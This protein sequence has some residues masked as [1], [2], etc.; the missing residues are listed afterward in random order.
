MPI[1]VGLWKMGEMPQRV[2]FSAMETE[3]RLED[4]LAKDLSILDP[5]L[6]LIGRQVPTAYG[7][8]I[9]LLA[10]DREGNLNVIELKRNK[11]PREVVAQVL[12]YGS[13]VRNL[14]DDDI[15]AIFDTYK[16]KYHPEDGTT[17]LDEA[18]CKYFGVEEMPEAI[19]ES[20]E[21]IVVAAELDHSTERIINYL[22]EF[23]VAINAVFFRF[24]KDGESEYLSRAWLIEPDRVEENVIGRREKRPWNGEFYVSFGS[25]PIRNWE[26]ARKY[27]FISAG[28]GSW[29]TKT[30]GTLEQGARIWVNIPRE[31][32]VGVGRVVDKV[33]PVEEFLV[34]DGTGNRVPIVDLPLDIAK[35]TKAKDDADNA[36]HLVRVEWIKTV[37]VSEAI[38]EKGFFG[39]QN[40]VAKPRSKKWP[41]TVERLKARFGVTD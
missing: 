7:K 38:S 11:T 16:R 21:L 10:M 22:T 20:H 9:D 39:N 17:S 12:D 4:V 3:K 2:A 18:F 24:F 13:W 6:L 40:T 8:F 37:P 23:G 30:L 34:D 35:A 14:E 29:Y 32:Y 5:E 36:E 41:H 25:N 15:A 33:V 31:G 19:N 26:E 27:G 28:G 1:E